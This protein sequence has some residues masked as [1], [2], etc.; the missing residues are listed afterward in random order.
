MKSWNRALKIKFRSFGKRRIENIKRAAGITLICFITVPICLYTSVGE[1]LDLAVLKSFFAIRGAVPPPNNIV[2]AALDDQSYTQLDASVR[3]PFPRKYS[4]EVIERI[5]KVNPRIL[6]LDLIIPK[7][8]QDPQAN[9]RLE[10]A[11]RAGIVTMVSG[12]HAKANARE[13]SKDRTANTFTIPS[14]PRFEGAAK[15]LLDMWVP[16]YKGGVFRVSVDPDENAPL[17]KRAPLA[18]ALNKLAGYN[19]TRPGPEDLINYYGPKGT[20]EQ[21]PFYEILKA[22]DDTLRSKFS[23]KI[24]LAGLH[25]IEQGREKMKDEFDVPVSGTMFG[26][27]IHANL[28]GNFIQNSWLRR[29][30]FLDEAI[31]TIL[32]CF[33]VAFIGMFVSFRYATCLIIP[34]VSGTIV[35][36]Y[37]AFLHHNRWFPLVGPMLFCGTLTCSVNLLAHYFAADKKNKLNDRFWSFDKED[38]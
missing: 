28:V 7:E 5:T 36:C 29:M 24:V 31:I 22:D 20:I 25:S 32:G 3:W 17:E 34:I 26:V 21:V 35:A 11:M 16:S 19:I 33:L 12:T 23:G 4:A 2:I 18:N 38:E 8:D 27:E 15:M 13:V 37:L 6:I 10:K 1:D 14:D 9:E 30:P